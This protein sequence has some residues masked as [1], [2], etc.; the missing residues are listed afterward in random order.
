MARTKKKKNCK[1]KYALAKLP[2]KKIGLLVFAGGNVAWH[3]C[4]GKWLG[5]ASKPQRVAI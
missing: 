5:C 2:R 3:G 1:R 4:C